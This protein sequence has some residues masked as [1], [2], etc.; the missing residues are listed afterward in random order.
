MSENK[1]KK[2]EVVQCFIVICDDC[3]ASTPFWSESAAQEF[4]DELNKQELR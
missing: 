3:V 4:A 1:C 2:Y